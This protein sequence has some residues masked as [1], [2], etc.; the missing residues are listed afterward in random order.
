MCLEKGQSCTARRPDPA[1]SDNYGNC[2]AACSTLPRYICLFPAE[3]DRKTARRQ[4][5]SRF[6]SGLPGYRLNAGL[7]SIAIHQPGCV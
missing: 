6:R 4:R 2:A 3:S 1:G 7:V 5:P